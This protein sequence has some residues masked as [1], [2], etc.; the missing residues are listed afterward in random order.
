[1]AIVFFA[2]KTY[3][4]PTDAL[5]SF[6]FLKQPFWWMY[7]WV[8]GKM[9]VCYEKVQIIGMDQAQQTEKNVEIDKIK[10]CSFFVGEHC[11]K[12]YKSKRAQGYV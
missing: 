2:E 7:P 12:S 5:S 11:I 3:L 10:N 6:S 1:M 4:T 9:L 8:V